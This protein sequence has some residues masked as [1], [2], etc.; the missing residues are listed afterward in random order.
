MRLP[1][2]GLKGQEEKENKSESKNLRKRRTETKRQGQRQTE[3][4]WR[5][6]PTGFEAIG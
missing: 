3:R 4:T 1:L 6:H 2:L 5:N